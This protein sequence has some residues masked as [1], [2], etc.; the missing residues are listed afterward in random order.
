MF[1]A[2][3]LS[4]SSY[5]LGGEYLLSFFLRLPWPWQLQFNMEYNS[6]N[7]FES[8]L[9]QEHPYQVVSN[10]AKWFRRNSLRTVDNGRRTTEIKV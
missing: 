10:L 1:Q 6:L 9:C 5:G 2:K 4:S 8:A 3:Y 7:N